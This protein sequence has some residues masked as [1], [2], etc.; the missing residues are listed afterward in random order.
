MEYTATDFSDKPNGPAAERPFWEASYPQGVSSA[1]PLPPPT[2]LEDLLV[3]AA[4]KWP[5]AEAI[6]FYDHRITYGELLD[7]AARAARGF[8]SLGVGPGVSVG[9]HL[10]NT[11]HYVICS[12]GI[13]MAGG[14]VVPFSPHA[15][16]RELKEQLIDVE[17]RVM[18]TLDRASLYPR[19]AALKGVGRLETIVVCRIEDFLPAEFAAKVYPIP[20]AA[21]RPGT[22]RE[23]EFSELID[24]DGVYTSHPHGPLEDEIAAIAY[25]GGTTGEP[26][27]VMLT[28]ANFS[29][30]VNIYLLWTSQAYWPAER[31][32]L[33]VLP[34]CHI[35]G[36][37]SIM[38]LVVATG[39]GLVL[40]LG[41]DVNRVLADLER[42]KITTFA[43]V[44]AMYSML[45]VH[46]KIRE[47]DLSSLRHCNVGGAPLPLDVLHRF[48]EL[49]GLTPQLGYGLTE[50]T[51]LAALQIV[52]GEQRLGTSGL[53]MPHTMIEIVDLETGMEVLPVGEVGEICCCGPHL[54]KGYWKR[55]EETEKAFYGG[56]F[57]TGD[58]GFLDRDGYLTIVDR[59][60]E[61]IIT[62]GHNVF[63]RNIE[64][65]IREHAAVAEVAVLGVPDASLGQAL[66]AFIELSPGSE[67]LSYDELRAFLRDKVASYETPVE[68]EIRASLPKTPVGKLAKKELIEELRRRDET[69]DGPAA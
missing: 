50:T 17:A 16:P 37:A 32:A 15:A 33:V 25:S 64:K 41:F 38:I 57:H 49:T 9:L 47:F 52:D 67:P 54:M 28:H 36:F 26:K 3:T 45:V 58:I 69:S 68:M 39:A 42:K 65:V 44:P 34:L 66:K 4:Q 23:V 55:P 46:S 40:H 53:P 27:G 6:D 19:I 1:E 30:V 14:R 8:Q 12:F 59:K 11:P 35:F 62:G 2:P 56:R 20:A 61:M 21:R 43:G 31:K 22:G 29:A 60:K 7:A 18:V 48:R 5:E 51:A 10:L 63:P 24:N 13:L